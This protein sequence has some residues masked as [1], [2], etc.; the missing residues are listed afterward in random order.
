MDHRP[1]VHGA[2]LYRA[3]VWAAAAA[4]CLT[5]GCAATGP[6]PSY[7]AV[8]RRLVRLDSDSNRDGVVDHRIYMDGK[9]PLRA[10]FD[11]DGNGR[12]DRWEYYDNDV[13]LTVVGTSAAGDGLEDTWTWAADASG[14]RRV[15]QS[16]VRDRAIDRREFFRN[17]ALVRAEADTNADG[18][19]DRWETFEAGTLVLVAL[20]TTFAGDRPNRRLAY[21]QE[22]RFRF[23]EADVDGDG[24]WQPTN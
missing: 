6:V 1:V 20:D 22:G 12:V 13:R 23:I 4:A 2:K 8:T 19:I 16:L 3:A 15:D 21:D 17:G 14:E 9:T 11:A 24:K 7:D 5:G 18:R 10:E